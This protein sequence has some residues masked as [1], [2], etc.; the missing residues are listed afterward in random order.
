MLKTSLRICVLVGLLFLASR[1]VVSQEIV[2]A[3]IGS[4]SSINTPNGTITLLLDSGSQSTFKAMSSSARHVAFD[5][6][7]AED[8]VPANDFGN[9]GAYVIVF[10]FGTEEDRT[11][12]AVKSLGAGPFSS[13]TGEVSNWNGHEHSLS[14]RG[15][16]KKE[17][18]FKVDAQS[19]AET[20]MGA[21]NASK[22]DIEKGDL[23]R[24][25]SSM[26]NGVPTVLFIRQK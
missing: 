23:V 3:L 11:A 1:E 17:H 13:L 20:Y 2:H 25:V 6:K 8:A 21:V 14:V 15:D 16:D 26:K 9:K 7:V 12:I 10:Y 22:F 18:L 4:V 19:V 24:L 5:K